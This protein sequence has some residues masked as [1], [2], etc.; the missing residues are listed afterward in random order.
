MIL[1]GGLIEGLLLDR[2]MTDPK[3]AKAQYRGLNPAQRRVSS[4]KDWRLEDLIDV[5][6]AMGVISS[7]A[8]SLSQTLRKWRNL[9][10]TSVEIRSGM[11]A[12]REEASIAVEMVK[13]VLRDLPP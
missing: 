9:V 3:A 7:G 1:C 6:A 4:P 2:L 8:R 12:N 11:E 5:A 10:H 13:I